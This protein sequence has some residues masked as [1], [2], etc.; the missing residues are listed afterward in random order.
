MFKDKNK[1]QI[2]DV[3]LNRLTEGVK[4]IEDLLRYYF[5]DEKNLRLLRRQKQLLWKRFDKIRKLVISSRQSEKD[6]GRKIR[7]DIHKRGKIV[8]I[9]TV[10]FKRGQES[11]RVL[12]ELFKSINT[13]HAGFFK[14]LRFTLYDL[15]K[16]M[17]AQT[18]TGFEPQVYVILDINTIGRK[19]LPVITKACIR[20]GATMLQLREA[21]RATTRQWLADARQIQK[22]IGNAKIK[23]IINNRIDVCLAV[24]ADGAHL[25][26]TDMPLIYVRKILGEDK[27]IGITVH[28]VK[29]ARKAEKHDADYLGF[30][31]IF[32]TPSKNNIQVVGLDKLKQ[33]VQAVKIPVIAIGGINSQNIQQVVRTKAPGV[34]VI[35]AVFEGVDFI[36]PGFS[37]KII[38]N[39]RKLKSKL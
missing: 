32:S 11:A 14:D 31:A 3:N 29:Q 7:F 1:D 13:K 34:A 9:L 20:G 10:N 24:N 39:I 26:Q 15:E 23:F 28:N 35:S 12:E 4:V 33:I 16:T 8:D 22:G 2:I 38:A 17:S 27:L 37:N 30:G 19:H 6:L 5:R 18:K 21:E 25:G 36:K